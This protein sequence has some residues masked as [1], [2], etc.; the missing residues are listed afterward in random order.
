MPIECLEEMIAAIDKKPPVTDE[1]FEE[2]IEY[3]RARE[4]EMPH[5]QGN[6]LELAVAMISRTEIESILSTRKIRHEYVPK[7]RSHEK[8]TGHGGARTKGGDRFTV[9]FISEEKN[10][11]EG[12]T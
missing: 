1:E 7:L 4:R 6:N 8:H 12:D 3:W 5:K 10:S 9:T 11:F 2:A